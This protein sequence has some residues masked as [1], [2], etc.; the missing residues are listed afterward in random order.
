MANDGSWS[1]EDGEVVCRQLG[2]EIPS[3]FYSITPLFSVPGAFLNNIIWPLL[4]RFFMYVYVCYFLHY[5]INSPNLNDTLIQQSIY[6]EK[7]EHIM[8]YSPTNVMED[9]FFELS[10]I[11]TCIIISAYVVLLHAIV[12][13]TGCHHY[14][15]LLLSGTS[16]DLY[17][18]YSTSYRETT[19]VHMSYVQ[20]LGT[21]S[22]LIDCPHTSG[23]SGSG[24]TPEYGLYNPGATLECYPY[25]SGVYLH[26]YIYMYYAPVIISLTE[27]T[28]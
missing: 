16:I 12:K 2:F 13:D 4:I 25:S 1:L 8:C 15:I 3:M 23:N 18:S 14:S 20:C 10:T 24:V 9:I 21:E 27:C 11:N 6:R 22:R 28:N 17:G 26:V 19:P 7:E 5:F